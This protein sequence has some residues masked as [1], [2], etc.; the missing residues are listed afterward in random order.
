MMPEDEET[1]IKYVLVIKDDFSGFVELIPCK[2]ADAATCAQGL[3]QWFKRFG[4]ATTWVSD[5]GA[6]FKN[7]VIETLARVLGVQHHFVTA[8]CPWSNGTV[9]V[10]NR[11][12]LKCLR[13]LLSERKIS[14]ARWESVLGV[15]QMALNYQPADRLENRAPVTAFTCLPAITPLSVVFTTNGAVV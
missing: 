8:Y 1:H 3:L 6:H 5:Q 14:R 12:L 13:A 10:V 2:S 9:E 15:V 11:L 4:V 7:A